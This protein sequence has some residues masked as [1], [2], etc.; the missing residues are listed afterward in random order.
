MSRRKFI[1]IQ[2]CSKNEFVIV[3]QSH[4]GMDF[5]T[6]DENFF[7]DYNDIPLEMTSQ[8]FPENTLCDGFLMV[9]GAN[10]DYDWKPLECH[11]YEIN[12]IL[13]LIKSYNEYYGR[14]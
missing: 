5:G 8:D 14:K 7:T 1:G 3:F 11:E 4:R 10:K 6:L 2:F 13:F 12:E 9:R